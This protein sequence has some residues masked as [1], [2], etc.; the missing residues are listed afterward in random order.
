MHV[1]RWLVAASHR[2]DCCLSWLRP[3]FFLLFKFVG[4]HHGIPLQR[5]AFSWFF[6][7]LWSFPNEF[8]TFSNLN[9]VVWQHSDYFLRVF[10]HFRSWIIFASPW[11]SWVDKHVCIRA[12]GGGHCWYIQARNVF[13]VVRH[14]RMWCPHDIGRDSWVWGEQETLC[15]INSPH[16][17][18]EEAPRREELLVGRKRGV[19]RVR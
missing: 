11:S 7:T 10:M 3:A 19:P 4:F 17:V 18:G 16:E 15:T 6:I 12:P 14:S 8:H 2:L 1:R 13:S 5:N 9:F